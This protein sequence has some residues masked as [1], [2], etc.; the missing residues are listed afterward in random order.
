MKKIAQSNTVDAG[1]GAWNFVGRRGIVYCKQRKRSRWAGYMYI[2]AGECKKIL[3]ITVYIVHC[4]RGSRGDTVT[5]IYAS[6]PWKN[7]AW[8]LKL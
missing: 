5:V 6:M 4:A 3:I 8:Q 2:G 1:T 7:P